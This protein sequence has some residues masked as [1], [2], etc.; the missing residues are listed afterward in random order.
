M[1]A[2][3][4][5]FAQI[6]QT[7]STKE[8]TDALAQYFSH[9]DEKDTIWCVALLIGK[10]PRRTVKTAELFEWCTELSGIPGWLVG[11]CWDVVG[12]LAE[13]ISLLLPPA[14]ELS[15]YPLHK[16][17]KGLMALGD[18][19]SEA[20]KE[21]ITEMWRQL[22]MQERFVF[23]KL[24]TGG[25]RVGVSEKIVIKALAQR[26]G[27]DENIVAH[28]MMGTWDPESQTLHELLMTELHKSDISKPYPF[29]LA[30]ALDVDFEE[31]GDIS[32]WQIERKYDGIRGQIILRNSQLFVWSRGEDLLTFKF[33]EFQQLVEIFPDG[34]VLDGEILPVKDGR[35]LPFHVMQTRIGR[36][37]VTKKSLQE[38]PLAMIV[39][40]L[41]EYNGEDFRNE[42]IRERRRTLEHLVNTAKL[43][44]NTIPI[45][46]SPLVNCASWEE[47]AHERSRSRELECEGLMLKRLDGQ[48]KSGRRRGEWWKWKID[49]YAVD[50]VLLYAQPGHGRRANL[51]TDYT[52]AVWDGEELVPFTKAYSGLTDKEILEVD[53]WIKRNTLEKF[54]P[55]RSVK[56]ELVFE[57]GFEGINPSPR[58]KSGVAL[59]FPRILRWR[60]DK[61]IADAD[62]KERLMQLLKTE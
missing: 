49:P 41:L 37:N 51:F 17:V 22:T 38:A 9:A 15:D 4:K 55:V 8:K 62:T 58:H 44:D 46:L 28:R 27:I 53:G 32:N 35:V 31:L 57:I 23:N 42:P 26:Y 12:D 60:K 50:G 6:D 39:Y 34:I 7:T 18:K 54:G 19:D 56:P 30:Y 59:R 10:R 52:F 33:P 24:I 29:Y 36:K 11:E 40:D 1:Q 5:L 16:I 20:R 2:F 3:S 47:A 13:T 14:D 45:H 25:F 48:Y 61:T 43:I 21:F